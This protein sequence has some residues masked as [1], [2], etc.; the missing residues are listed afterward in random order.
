MEILNSLTH[1]HKV[2][3]TK[4]NKKKKRKKP[5]ALTCKSFRMNTFCVRVVNR[6]N[7][8]TEDIVNISAVLSFKTLYDIYM[9][10]QKIQNRRYLLKDSHIHCNADILLII[11]PWISV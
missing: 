3:T 9:G 8:L 7:D 4:K 5:R 6:L 10:D 1:K 11:L 2:T